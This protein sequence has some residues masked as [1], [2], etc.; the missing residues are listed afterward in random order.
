MPLPCLAF[1][2]V[3]DRSTVLF[4]L[5]DKKPIAAGG[6]IGALENMIIC[7]TARGFMLARDPT[8]LSTFLWSSQSRLKIRLPPLGLDVDDDL[9]IECNCLLSDKPTAPGCVVLLGPARRPPHMVLS[10]RG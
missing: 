4:S 10:R 1:Q 8:S 9:P 5:S 2:S 7:P 6:D 3:D